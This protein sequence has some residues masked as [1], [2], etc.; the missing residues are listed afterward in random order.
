MISQP[1]KRGGH[2]RLVIGLGAALAALLF[3]L[4]LAEEMLEGDTQAFDDSLRMLIHQYATPGLTALMQL[5]SFLGSL[6]CLSGL[7]GLAALYLA[8]LKKWRDLIH[9][10]IIM[11][12]SLILENGLKIGFHRARPVSFFGTPTPPTYSFPSGHALL[13]LCFYGAAAYLMTRRVKSRGGRILV[14]SLTA[15][16]VGLIGLSRIYLGV[17][18]PSDVLAGYAVAT[19]WVM[20]VALA[21]HFYRRTDDRRSR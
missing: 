8:A 17:H 19:I 9:L 1:S 13:S 18:Y 3:F 11:V 12:G 16:L 4:W 14:F 7:S 2:A 20:S 5:F 10:A 21:D 6:A 15:L